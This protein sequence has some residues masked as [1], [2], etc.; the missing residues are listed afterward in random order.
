VFFE[1][2]AGLVTGCKVQADDR[3]G[4]N[5]DQDECQHGDD[6]PGGTISGLGR[7]LGDAHG[8]DEEVGDELERLHRFLM[9]RCG[10]MIAKKRV[11]ASGWLGFGESE[12]WVVHLF[13]VYPGLCPGR[14]LAAAMAGA[15]T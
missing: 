5:G 14:G 4:C 1:E 2:G 8:V 15:Y 3:D 9:R 13:I 7:R 6:E 12:G 10:E 11:A